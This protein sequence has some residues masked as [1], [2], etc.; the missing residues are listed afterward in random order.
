MSTSA[1]KSTKKI[2][3][4]QQAELDAAAAA[5]ALVTPSSSVSGPPLASGPS[6]AVPLAIGPPIYSIPNMADIVRNEIQADDKRPKIILLNTN[7]M[8][9]FTYNLFSHDISHDG[10]PANLGDDRF[11]KAIQQDSE[12]VKDAVSESHSSP[13]PDPLLPAPVPKAA[14]KA[15]A[16]AAKDA[17]KAA[18]KAAA[19]A[20]KDA[21]K[22]AKAPKTKGGAKDDIYFDTPYKPYELNDSVDA[23]IGSISSEL[24]E[25]KMLF[26]SMDRLRDSNFMKH[27]NRTYIIID[28]PHIMELYNDDINLRES[29]YPGY[30]Y[31][32]NSVVLPYDIRVTSTKTRPPVYNIEWIDY[33]TKNS[34]AIEFTKEI[35]VNNITFLQRDPKDASGS[36]A[37]R[38]AYTRMTTSQRGADSFK[39]AKE[40][41]G[42][43]FFYEVFSDYM[44][45]KSCN[46]IDGI[47]SLFPFFIQKRFEG[48]IVV[49]SVAE[50]ANFLTVL[51]KENY[52]LYYNYYLNI[53]KTKF[54]TDLPYYEVTQ[55]EITTVQT[56][57]DEP[58]VNGYK[59]NYI[60]YL[61]QIFAHQ[62]QYG[63]NIE[64]LKTQYAEIQNKI[65]ENKPLIQ[66]EDPSIKQFVDFLT[67]SNYYFN[68]KEILEKEEDEVGAR[69]EEDEVGARV[70]EDEVGA[71]V[72]VESDNKGG[73]SF[74]NKNSR[75]FGGALSYVNILFENKNVFTLPTVITDFSSFTNNSQEFN[76]TYKLDVYPTP[77]GNTLSYRNILKFIINPLPIYDLGDFYSYAVPYREEIFDMTSDGYKKNLIRLTSILNLILAEL[78]KASVDQNIATFV[79]AT[80]TKAGSDFKSFPTSC[81]FLENTE[82]AEHHLVDNPSFINFLKKIKIF[83]QELFRQIKIYIFYLKTKSVGGAVDNLTVFENNLKSNI[84]TYLSVIPYVS[85]IFVADPTLSQAQK[86]NA[87][88]M[89]ASAVLSMSYYMK[90]MANVHPEDS[91]ILSAEINMLSNIFLKKNLLKGTAQG[92][93]DEK[94]VDEFVS[95]LTPGTAGHSGTY[96]GTS[97]F[98]YNEDDFKSSDTLWSKTG[99]KKPSGKKT[100]I[101]NAA[102]NPIADLPIFFCPFS[103]IMDG[104]STCNSYESALRLNNYVEI[105]FVD[106]IVRDGVSV[107]NAGDDTQ[108]TMRYH[109]KVEKDTAPGKWDE[110]SSTT[111]RTIK[112]SA[113]LKIGNEVIINIGKV[114][115]YA[116]NGRPYIYVDLNGS[117]SPLEAP[118][119]LKNI[120]D[121]SISSL[122]KPDNTYRTW[123]EY[124]VFL[125][126]DSIITTKDIITDIESDKTSRQIRNEI[127]S[128]SFVKSLGDYLQE[129]N[130]VAKHGGYVGPV[131]SDLPNTIQDPDIT[132]RA[133]PR[134]G[135]SN[136]RPSGVRIVL[137]LLFGQT[138]INE[139]SFGGYLNGKGK[140]LLAV[141]DK[142][143]VGVKPKKKKG[144]NNIN[145]KT[146]RRKNKNK[147][148]KKYD[149]KNKKTKKYKRITKKNKRILKRK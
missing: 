122:R 34:F 56:K 111:S 40:A 99:I 141:R 108:E 109:V 7:E 28:I 15:A 80:D 127:L 22:A 45:N 85:K 70:E 74:K 103:S 95:W 68:T 23:I 120:M 147:T 21:A 112:I 35:L 67:I 3:K 18:D 91:T 130:I 61:A 54:I 24:I 131:T 69:V 2:T 139:D 96:F 137:L 17:E 138:D 36:L 90:K 38:T 77:P 59:N 126:S 134:F 144:G 101:N 149:R 105:G 60:T 117:S 5:A 9:F 84:I 50:A 106:V 57:L 83:E 32:N 88:Y 43:E 4:K 98:L 93:I 10:H 148:K 39:E 20:A 116:I 118:T 125:N 44:E 86:V 6:V 27:Q 71:R 94:L 8:A 123:D 1:S 33:E 76:D 31:F 124:L 87:S 92:Q 121:V 52:L 42:D 102:T 128:A 58:G 14:A 79:T 146:K 41:L 47:Y 132:D 12:K 110:T 104:Q 72:G 143:I 100:F 89:I 49:P 75:Q 13:D 65:S 51:T 115:D 142:A 25:N 63:K 53:Y 29:T 19:K 37:S 135:L 81:I 11:Q 55:E 113:Y 78:S 145:R 30:I 48:G 119:C 66:P 46:K 73:S 97:D 16:K 82:S 140:Y 26:V 129:L 133:H 136:D 62:I 64:D 114:G 107:V